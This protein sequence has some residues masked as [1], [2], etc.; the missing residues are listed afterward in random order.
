MYSTISLDFIVVSS[1]S[2]TQH[3]LRSWLVSRN[4]L[5]S[6]S[7]SE[8]P[9]K[10]FSIYIYLNLNIMRCKKFIFS[11]YALNENKEAKQAIFIKKVQD[12]TLGSIIFK[13]SY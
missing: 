9:Q 5:S 13:R 3:Q 1:S 12:S 2:P 10:L 11:F 6:V 4:S 7:E 8:K